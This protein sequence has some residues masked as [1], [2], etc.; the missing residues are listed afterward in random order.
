MSSRETETDKLGSRAPG[1]LLTSPPPDVSRLWFSFSFLEVLENGV[2][3]FGADDG[4]GASALIGVAKAIS[5]KLVRVSPR[6][7]RGHPFLRVSPSWF[8]QRI[9]DLHHGWTGKLWI[10]ARSLKAKDVMGVGYA[11]TKGICGSD[12]VHL[13]NLACRC[14]QT[15]PR[16][17]S[18]GFGTHG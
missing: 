13:K 7:C 9:M 3:N 15:A 6:S 5:G 14:S 10:G 4:I 18:E 11:S 17:T 16:R 1:L 12:D 8:A 2:A